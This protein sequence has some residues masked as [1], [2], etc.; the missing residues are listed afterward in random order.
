MPT[1]L[2]F[3]GNIFLLVKH[4]CLIM[5]PQS[6]ISLLH[7]VTGYSV[8]DTG[9][10][11]TLRIILVHVKTVFS[12]TN[13]LTSENTSS[14]SNWITSIHFIFL[15]VKTGFDVVQT[16]FPNSREICFFVTIVFPLVEI[17][18]HY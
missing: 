6:K 5:Y 8:V 10:P 11:I 4:W 16:D 3:S 1:S 9:L 15:S 13:F 17:F 2:P 14:C 12:T 18:F 7:L